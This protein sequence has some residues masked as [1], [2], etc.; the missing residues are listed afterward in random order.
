MRRAAAVS[1]ITVL[2]LLTALPVTAQETQEPEFDP[3]TPVFEFFRS[4]ENAE[5]VAQFTKDPIP[6]VSM[7]T[8]PTGDFEHSTG[9]TPGYTPDHIDITD[10]WVI[11]FNPGDTPFFDATDA[12]GFWAPTGGNTVDLP[13]G[14]PITTFTG[15][16]VHDGSQYDNGAYLFGF[17]LRAQPPIVVA[18]QC[19][20]VVW[21]RDAS[22]S[23]I[24]ENLP[25]FPGDPAG[26]TNM[27]FGLGI[28]PE[29]QGQS[30]TF[31]LDLTGSGGFADHADADIRSFIDG[32]YVAITAPKEL[33]G[34]LGGVNF[35]TFCVKEGF[36]FDPADT[37]ADQ[38]GLIEMTDDDL[39]IIEMTLVSTVQTTTTIVETTTTTIGTTESTVEAGGTV[40]VVD[41][42]EEGGFPWGLVIGGGGIF[43]ALIGWWLYNQEDD[44][45]KE[46]LKAWQAAQKACDEAQAA[47]DDAADDCEDAEIELEDLEQ[48]RKD[49]CELWPP[50]CW[51]TDEGAWVEDEAGNRITSRDLLMK[52]MALGE[53]WDDYKAGKLTAQEVEAKW[54]EA[55]TPEF[56]EDMRET[57]EAAREELDRIDEEIEQ[58]TK[59][60]EEACEEAAKAQ[61]K[62]DEACAAAEAARKAYED[63]VGA[64][65]ASAA[66]GSDEGAEGGP[67]VPGGAG[68]ATGTPG[69]TQPRDPCAG[70][71]PKRE[72]RGPTGRADSIR[73][74]VDFSVIVGRS[75]GS[76]RRI[77]AGQHLTFEL[78]DLARDLDFAGDMLSA[79]SA[80]LHLGGAM[81][82][83]TAGNYVATTSG[84]IRGGVDA[85]TATDVAPDIPTTPL[86]AGT[87]LLEQTARL[88]AFVAGKVTEWMANYQIMTVRRSYFYQTIT[89]TPHEIWECREGTGWVCVEKIWAYNVGRL[90]V[91][92]GRDNWFTVNSTRRR[93]VFQREIRRISQAAANTIKRDA[94]RLAE[95]RAQH[96]PGPC[97]G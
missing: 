12:D 7:V 30:S 48:D 79:R 58:A 45:C 54:R 57:D 15:D 16:L 81:N 70:V 10:A 27:A 21:V 49:I 61:E 20:Y 25:S 43:L 18:G 37:G 42:E 11:D 32:N 44:P 83:Y 63:C 68:V 52:R 78:K 73:V 72:V 38:T 41:E 84:V 14:S 46:L 71:D 77:A 33:I 36:S 26:G 31:A 23:D 3:L 92:R 50:A 13:S 34:D 86:Q 39:G 24:F 91:L 53:V 85:V 75:E 90:R 51:S 22:R 82:G 17:D 40:A 56:R 29:G 9:Q 19:E 97:G 28:N 95:W 67:T 94:Q 93:F 96:E 5:W 64:A 55:D 76:E 80:G 87:E 88:G 4:P 89:A 8:D 62:A 47:A 59:D 6:G 35:Y 66:E 1:T 69:G 74:N 65:V 60:S 2:L